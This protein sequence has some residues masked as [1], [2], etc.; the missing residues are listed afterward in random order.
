MLSS[1][2]EAL[3]KWMQENNVTLEDLQK[4]KDD[5]AQFRYGQRNRRIK[6]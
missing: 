6:R 3:I 1:D 2:D 4:I 5:N